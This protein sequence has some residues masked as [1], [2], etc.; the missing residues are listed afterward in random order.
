MPSRGS[1]A[2]ISRSTREHQSHR[3]VREPDESAGSSLPLESSYGRRVSYQTHDLD[4]LRGEYLQSTSFGD[5][6][7][8]TSIRLRTGRNTTQT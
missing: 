1:L 8:R 4:N 5:A 2:L 3:S 6:V 7:L